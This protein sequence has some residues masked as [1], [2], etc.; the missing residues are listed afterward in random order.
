MSLSPD[1]TVTATP[2]VASDS[3]RIP[4]RPV[5]VAVTSGVLISPDVPMQNAS[6]TSSNT[7]QPELMLQKIMEDLQ[8]QKNAFQ[9]FEN[10]MNQRFAE[11]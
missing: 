11:V 5:S 4:P 8:A 6:L 10:T 1:N 7:L 9:S 3:Q 2:V